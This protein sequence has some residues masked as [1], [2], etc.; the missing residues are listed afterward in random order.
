MQVMKASKAGKGYQS[1]I[2]ILKFLRW[3]GNRYVRC[4]DDKD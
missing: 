3:C 2:D 1:T 4:H